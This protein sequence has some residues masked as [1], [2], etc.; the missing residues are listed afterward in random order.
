[1]RKEL[2]LLCVIMSSGD[3][4]DPLYACHDLHIVW[5]SQAGEP[6]RSLAGSGEHSEERCHLVFVQF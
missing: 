6:W 5:M 2:G 1:M 3:P 4:L